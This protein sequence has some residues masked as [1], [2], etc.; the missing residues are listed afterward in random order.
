MLITEIIED[1]N[2]RK[3]LETQNFLTQINFYRILHDLWLN[4]FVLKIEFFFFLS[5]LNDLKN[6]IFVLAKNFL[7]RRVRIVR[8]T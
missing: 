7:N 2:T 5:N 6:M 3:Y 8:A 1:D 4:L